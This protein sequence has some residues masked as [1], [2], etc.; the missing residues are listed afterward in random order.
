MK[1][2]ALILASGACAALAVSGAR[3]QA[4]KPP[5]RIAWLGITNRE[6][7]QPYVD[8]FKTKFAELGFAEGRDY[9]IDMRYAEGSIDRLPAL[10]RELLALK[11]D[12]VIASTSPVAA[13]FKKE[14]STI[15]VVFVSIVDPE[16]QGFVASLARPGGNMTGVGFRGWAMEAKLR[17]LVRETLPAARRFAVLTIEGDRVLDRFLPEIRARFEASGFEI[18][19]TPV[20]DAQDFERAF[21]RLVARKSEVI[22]VPT[23]GFFVSQARRLGELALKARLPMV[24]PRRAFATAGGLFSYDNDL[25]DDFRG[26]AAFVAK[27]LKGAKPADLPVEQ[28]DRFHL[29]VNLR[30]AKALGIK[31]PQSILLRADEV[32]E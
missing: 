15:P 10:A 26:A 22:Y 5:R 17:E 30:T 29:A 11:P 12:L 28:P 14:T 21:A 13:V 23:A 24:G 1:R 7:G 6:N 16:A 32:I 25:K 18:D 31:I 19:V 4:P 20:K 3:A 2:R 9:V 27:I 8:A